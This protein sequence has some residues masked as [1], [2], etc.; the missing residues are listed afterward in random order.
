MPAYL[1]FSKSDDQD[2]D[3]NYCHHYPD[4]CSYP[5]LLFLL[6]LRLNVHILSASIRIENTRD[7]DCRLGKP[8]VVVAQPAK[9]FAPL[10]VTGWAGVI[11]VLEINRSRCVYIESVHV[12]FLN[13][14][15]MIANTNTIPPITIGIV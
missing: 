10:L 8:K 6:L 5:S 2:Y 1:L 4:Y 14:I 7:V 12:H 13:A 3:G 11:L 9:K 15:A